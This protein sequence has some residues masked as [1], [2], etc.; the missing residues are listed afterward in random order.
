MRSVPIP[1]KG[2][3]GIGGGMW[4][5]RRVVLGVAGAIAAADATQNPPWNTL[6]SFKIVKTAAQVGRYT[7]TL[8]NPY[9]MFLGGLVT[10]MGGLTANYGANTTGLDAIFRA[11]DID[12]SDVGGLGSNVDGTVELQFVQSTY[13]DAEVPDNTIFRLGL[14][15]A[16]GL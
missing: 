8:P 10:I 15:V 14:C 16:E 9:R 7:I 6:N 11:N 12:A 3:V 4:F 1:E 13:A 2:F 5:W